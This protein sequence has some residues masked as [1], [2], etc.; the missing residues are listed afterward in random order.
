MY[1][2]ALAV[3]CPYAQVHLL[4]FKC[5]QEAVSEVSIACNAVST[6]QEALRSGKHIALASTE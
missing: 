6:E 1:T 5:Y 3:L 4:M 2:T